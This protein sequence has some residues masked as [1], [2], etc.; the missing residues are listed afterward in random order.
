MPRRTKV[1]PLAQ[2]PHTRIAKKRVSEIYYSRGI[3]SFTVRKSL[4]VRARRRASQNRQLVTSA[5][6]EGMKLT[7]EITYKVHVQEEDLRA[8]II[9]FGG[10]FK[11][12]RALALLTIPPSALGF[13]PGNFFG[14]PCFC[15]GG[16]G[17]MCLLWRH[18]QL[19]QHIEKILKTPMYDGEITY[20]LSTEMFRQHG[21]NFEFNADWSQFTSWSETGTALFLFTNPFQFHFV[22]RRCLSD[23]QYNEVR[24]FV[25]SKV[26]MRKAP[27]LDKFIVPIAIIVV[28]VEIGLSAFSIVMT[29]FGTEM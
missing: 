4:N 24:E 11:H 1:K 17:L 16:F 19:R 27:K 25:A 8:P 20:T 7:D 26:P 12:W 14:T 9:E 28:L 29:K 5:I 23:T 21:E 6:I 13:V 2:F 22:L 15:L 18:V 3:L 10:L